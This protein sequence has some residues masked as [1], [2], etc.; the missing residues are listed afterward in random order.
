MHSHVP[1][2]QSRPVYYRHVPVFSQRFGD[3]IK[4]SNTNIF[5]GPSFF[6]RGLVPSLAEP[7]RR[8]SSVVGSLDLS[9]H[10][11]KTWRP[12]KSLRPLLNLQCIGHRSLLSS[13]K[14]IMGK[15]FYS[16]E[17][18]GVEG[19]R[20]LRKEETVPTRTPRNN[21]ETN[22]FYSP[23]IGYTTLFLI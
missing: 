8:P 19:Q 18:Y 20:D 9:A 3:L 11:N 22:S 1:T 21:G 12:D 5:Y 4:T 6:P 16:S 10:G 23:S 14:L 7:P 2:S 17:Y 15:F 13:G